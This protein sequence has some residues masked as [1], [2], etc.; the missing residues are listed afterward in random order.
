M[1]YLYY[2]W[3]E[4]QTGLFKLGMEIGV[5]ERKL[6]THQLNNS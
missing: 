1:I 4:G 5:K 6:G 2:V 3:I